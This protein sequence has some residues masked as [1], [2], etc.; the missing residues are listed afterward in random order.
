MNEL[1][2]YSI[3]KK[4][5]QKLTMAKESRLVVPSGERKEWH[6]GVLGDANS[7]TWNGWAYGP[8]CTQHREVCLIGSLCCTT[9]LEETL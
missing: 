3:K 5:K 9:E 1:I 2:L 6:F 7:Y 8:Y 4:T